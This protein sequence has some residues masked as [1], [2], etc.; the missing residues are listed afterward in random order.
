MSNKQ[1]LY[2][3]ILPTEQRTLW[4]ELGDTP[5]HF[6]LYGGT[7]LA[8]QLGHRESIDFDFF[9]K[10]K[11]HAKDIYNSIPYLKNSSIIQETEDTLTCL[12]E[13]DNKEI[14]VSFFGDLD[15]VNKIEEPLIVSNGITIASK[16]DIAGT[17]MAT[18]LDRVSVKDYL[19]I[20]ALL[21]DGMKLQDMLKCSSHIYGKM[22]NPSLSVKTLTYFKDLDKLPENIKED[23]IIAVKKYNKTLE[24]KRDRDGR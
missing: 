20:H 11:F 6:T 21:K 13:R 12:V 1:Q 9:S 14:H 2:L 24:N 22:F 18:I 16:K 5:N 10:E 15:F 4:Y 19:D 23:L 8:L 17:K 3:E 7:A